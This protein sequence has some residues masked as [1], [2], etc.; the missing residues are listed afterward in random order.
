M[1]RTTI[2]F[3]LAS[4][5]RQQQYYYLVL[6]LILSLIAS[7]HPPAGFILPSRL[8]SSHTKQKG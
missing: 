3:G 7:I 4:L 8:V 6:Y 1:L 5:S 2:R